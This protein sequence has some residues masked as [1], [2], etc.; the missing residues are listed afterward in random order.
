MLARWHDARREGLKVSAYSARDIRVWANVWLD[1][2]PE[3]IPDAIASARKMILR[4]DFGTVLARAI[5]SSI[6]RAGRGRARPAKVG[7]V[8]SNPIARSKNIQFFRYLCST[9]KVLPTMLNR[10]KRG[11]SRWPDFGPRRAGRRRTPT[12]ISSRTDVRARASDAAER[13]SSAHGSCC[14]PK[15]LIAS[16]SPGALSDTTD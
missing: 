4:G 3:L 12:A 7:V 16:G 1:E 8:G 15:I 5:A 13:K 11:G 2:H 14:P 9:F 6:V 10:G